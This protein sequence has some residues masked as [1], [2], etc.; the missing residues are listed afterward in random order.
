MAVENSSLQNIINTRSDLI[1][2]YQAQQ[3]QIVVQVGEVVENRIT[4]VIEEVLGTEINNHIGKNID[5]YI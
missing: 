5:I 1:D 2:H 4:R 3:S